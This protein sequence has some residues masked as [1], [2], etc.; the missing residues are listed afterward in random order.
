MTSY[1]ITDFGN[2]LTRYKNTYYRIN[3]KFLILE[4]YNDP[5][6]NYIRKQL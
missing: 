4:N 5:E 6:S 2:Q 3:I 1:F